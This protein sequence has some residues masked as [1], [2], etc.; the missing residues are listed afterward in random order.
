MG[1]DGLPELAFGLANEMGLW[2][3]V[4]DPVGKANWP[5]ES[6]LYAE[7]GHSEGTQI[8]VS[9]DRHAIETTRPDPIRGGTPRTR[10]SSLI[11]QKAA[12]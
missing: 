12:R 11:G 5:E 3:H 10:E 2:G 9:S 8:P 6:I 1:L 4:C 7:A